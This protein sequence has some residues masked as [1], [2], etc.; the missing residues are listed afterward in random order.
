MYVEPSELEASK[1]KVI[2]PE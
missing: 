2:S 1:W